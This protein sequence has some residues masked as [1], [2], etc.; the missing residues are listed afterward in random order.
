MARLSKPSRSGFTLVELLVVITIIALL[1][2]LLLPA[3][4]RAREAA[5]S[6][7]CANNLRTIGQAVIGFAGDKSLPSAGYHTVGSPGTFAPWNVAPPYTPATTRSQNAQ[8]LV[9]FT[10]YNQSWGFFYQILPNIENDNLWRLNTPTPAAADLAIRSTPISTYFCPSRRSPQSLSD[11]RVGSGAEVGA[12]DYALNI[13][14]T[15]TT[16][17]VNGVSRPM[18]STKD[19]ALGVYAPA[20]RPSTIDY[21]GPVNPSGEFIAGQLVP[22]YQVKFTD[23]NDGV[24]YTI[25]VSEKAMD[26]DLIAHSPTKGTQQDGDTHGFVAGFDKFDTTRQGAKAPVRDSNGINEYD[27]FGSA[28]YAGINVLMCD[29]S[30]KQI[31]FA[32]NN[33]VPATNNATLRAVNGTTI[34]V[35]M[36][37]MQRLC[38]RSDASTVTATDIDQ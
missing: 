29:G 13:G 30:V 3:I 37:L 21:Y 31:S 6:M 23:I 7:S 8:S 1:I 24:A 5:N 10:K 20:P 4:Q 2:A 34:N 12:N 9:P 15:V 18:I 22:G 25:L 19:P 33:S 32:I 16:T 17:L 11:I 28:H 14:P 26:P 38:C 27:A 35:Q 36:S